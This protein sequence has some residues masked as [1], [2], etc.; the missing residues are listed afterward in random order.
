MPATAAIKIRYLDGPRLKRAVLAGATRLVNNQRHLDEI[1]V[2]PVPD[3]DTGAN[4]AGTML[5][6]AEQVR[7]VIGSRVHAITRAMADSA[8]MGA[9]G[10][11][12]VILAQFLSGFADGVG[13][14]RRM[15]TDQFVA[16]ADIAWQNAQSA[17]ENPKEGTILTV[18]GEWVDHLKANRSHYQDFQ[19]LFSSSLERARQSL[20]ATTDK[21]SSL[22]EAGV[23]DAGAQGFVY[24]LEGIQEFL[25]AGRIR[26]VPM[27]QPPSDHY[28]AAATRAEKVHD[29]EFQYCTE[30]LLSGENLDASA[31]R[32][33]ISPLG[34][35][36]IVGGSGKLVRIHV[37]TNEPDEIFRIAG[38]FAQVSRTKVD[39]MLVQHQELAGRNRQVVT[40]V[41][42]SACDLPD[43]V[44]GEYAIDAVPLFVRF[45]SREYLDKHELTP[46]QFVLYMAESAPSTSQPSPAAFRQMYD[47]ALAEHE[48]V[49]SIHLSGELSGTLQ[50][51]RAVAAK[52]SENI[53]VV[54]GRNVSLALGMVVEE[55][56]RTARQGASL[57]EVVERAEQAARKVRLFA[58]L[59]DID[60][61][62]RGGRLGRFKGML[63][64]AL[65]I[66]PIVLIDDSGKARIT[67]R[68]KGAENALEELLDQV[69]AYVAG[70]QARFGVTH[71]GAPEA[72]RH[73]A[74]CVRERFGSTDVPITWAAPVLGAHGGPGC[75]AVAVLTE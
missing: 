49:V 7:G 72:A 15:T 18:M 10:N 36:L 31:I 66:K 27:P 40:V 23:V 50:S 65:S 42:D 73:C 41:T 29:L 64:K 1:N 60:H 39:D 59:D 32:R 70:G 55:A 52:V 62:V 74:D 68:P 51:A 11:S 24:I 9:R 17:L 58:V 67:A 3:G 46:E 45:G 57:D 43:E 25:E 48:S 53:R 44:V 71:V 38:T 54:D 63:A 75:Y 35:S 61:V 6:I 16:A 13:N 20:R 26:A 2:F 30:C 33:E 47:R 8:I 56:A 37:H 4:M 12:G 28:S 21:L 5:S 69:E 19:D 14:V 22:R 34:D